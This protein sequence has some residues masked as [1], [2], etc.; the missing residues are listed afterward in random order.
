MVRQT[1]ELPAQRRCE[2]LFLIQKS[3]P[4]GQDTKITVGRIVCDSTFDSYSPHGVN[5]EDWIYPS[6]SLKSFEDVVNELVYLI[7]VAG[8]IFFIKLPNM[9]IF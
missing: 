9:G 3:Y 1:S 5:G 4:A 8:I 7:K 6:R 2:V